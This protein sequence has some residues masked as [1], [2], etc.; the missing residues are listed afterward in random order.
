MH[1]T[2]YRARGHI[3]EVRWVGKAAYMRGGGILVGKSEG[4]HLEGL[5]VA[6]DM[7]KWGFK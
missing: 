4:Y 5:S 2:K 3:K 1:L 7:L 6:W